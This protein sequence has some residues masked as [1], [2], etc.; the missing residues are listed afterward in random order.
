CKKPL[1]AL[2]RECP[3]CHADLSLVVDYAQ[4]LVLG[5]ARAEQLTRLGRLGDAV[6]AYLEVLEVDPENAE[7]RRQVGQVAAA[8]RQF[9][10][11]TGR[12]SAGS[13]WGSL[14]LIVLVLAA[15]GLGFLLGRSTLSADGSPPGRTSAR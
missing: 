1:T 15:L 10:E 5:L 9:D 2:A 3:S 14:F 6:W 12:R 13:R 7:A 8:V 11:A 4:N